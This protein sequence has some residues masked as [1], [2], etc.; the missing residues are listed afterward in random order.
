MRQLDPKC[1]VDV[2]DVRAGF[3]DRFARR[4][5]ADRLF[6]SLVVFV[7]NLA[8]DLLEQI[9]HRYQ[10]GRAAVFIEHDRKR[11]LAALHL[12]QQF[13]DAL[14]LRDVLDRPHQRPQGDRRDRAVGERDQQLAIV[15]D[16]GDLVDRLL[17]HGDLRVPFGDHQVER[18]AGRRRFRHRHHV[19]A[20]CHHLAYDG[21]A[22]LNDRMDELALPLFEN[23][24]FDPDVDQRFDV[25]FGDVRSDVRRSA[26]EPDQAIGNPQEHRGQRRDDPRYDR[27]DRCQPQRHAVARA[28][29][30][31][32]GQNLAEEQD[33]DRHHDRRPHD[34]V[35]NVEADEQRGGERISRQQH[36]G[37]ADQHRRQ[38]AVPIAQEPLENLSAAHVLLGERARPEPVHGDDCRL[39]SRE[40]RGGGLSFR[41]HAQ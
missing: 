12:A 6:F 24:L 1:G 29:G 40:K 13:G 4:D 35:R 2:F 11:K 21:V 9:F 10:A 5:G 15:D 27:E 14:I 38:R 3:D 41:H 19:D 18:A 32:L 25:F 8:D 30:D 37:A 17:V 36:E 26:E 20:R 23:V 31:R 34:G 39:R 33:Q 7:A 16:A 28:D 22:E